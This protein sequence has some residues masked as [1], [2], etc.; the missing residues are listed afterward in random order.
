MIYGHSL[1]DKNTIHVRFY[2][3]TTENDQ[4]IE[5]TE[6]GTLTEKVFEL[7]RVYGKQS[8]TFIF[9]PGS[10]F[11][12]ASFKFTTKQYPYQKVTCSQSGKASW[13]SE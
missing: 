10:H 13:V 12:F 7:D 3:G 8:V 4:L 5:F 1:V 6:T 9:V 2:D 11:D